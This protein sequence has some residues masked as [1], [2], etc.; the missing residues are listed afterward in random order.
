MGFGMLSG[1]LAGDVSG[2]SG[3]ARCAVPVNTSRFQYAET[4]GFCWVFLDPALPAALSHFLYPTRF[5]ASQAA[6][7]CSGVCSRLATATVATSYDRTRLDATRQ[8]VPCSR[9][10]Q[11]HAAVRR[12]GSIIPRVP[13]C[14]PRNRHLCTRGQAMARERWARIHYKGQRLNYE[15]SN[16]GNVRNATTHQILS[17][18]MVRG[19]RHAN[20][21]LHG[22]N[23]QK[24]I[25]IAQ[26]VAKAFHGPRPLGKTIEHKDQNKL[27]DK[28]T[29][30]AYMTQAENIRRSYLLTNH[31]KGNYCKY[32][33]Q[34]S[35]DLI[36]DLWNTGLYS[37]VRIGL[38]V[39]L[40]S[41]MVS[42]IVRGHHHALPNGTLGLTVD[43]AILTAPRKKP[44][45]PGQ[46]LSD[47]QVLEIWRAKGRESTY[48]LSKRFGVS[49]TYVSALWYGAA[50]RAR[51]LHA[52]LPVATTGVSGVEGSRSN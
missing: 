9:D 15:V 39:G 46:K 18:Q 35:Y 13:S 8:P 42:R 33:S 51:R 5:C 6:P 49:R 32:L 26:L 19:R 14:K 30:L 4:R 21:Y 34:K 37:Q 50:R 7:V 29:N 36:H 2:R 3:T 43:W 23:K 52:A 48:S 27:N 10:H 20:L 45:Y 38:A 44:R 25:R 12:R 41:G 47:D 31:A 17:T 24:L 1:M 11:R 40:S 16:L 28:A 22:S